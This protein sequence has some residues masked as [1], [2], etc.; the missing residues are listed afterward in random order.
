MKNIFFLLAVG[1][2]VSLSSCKPSQ[3]CAESDYR[4]TDDMLYACGQGSGS[5]ENTAVEIA[6]IDAKQKMGEKIGLYTAEH[7]KSE[8]LVNDEAYNNKLRTAEKTVLTELGISCQVVK[9]SKDKYLAYVTL[10]ADLKVIR[11]IMRGSSSGTKN[12]D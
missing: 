12:K 3:P 5:R 1:I 6:I 7:Y 4:D 11:E 2:I 8:T 10:S 9:K